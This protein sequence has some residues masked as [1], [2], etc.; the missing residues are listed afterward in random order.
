MIERKIAVLG[1]QRGGTQ[2]TA[3]VLRAN[4]LEVKHEDLG[5]DGIVCGAFIWGLKNYRP[6]H[7]GFDRVV[8]LVRDP[9]ECAETMD[10]FVPHAF[11]KDQ[12]CDDRLCVTLRWWV[13]THHEIERIYPEAELHV[14]AH[15]LWRG[16][17]GDMDEQGVRGPVRGALRMNPETGEEYRGDPRPYDKRRAMERW[18]GMDP[19]WA[20]AG[21]V[22]WLEA[23]EGT[24]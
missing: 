9:I 2:Y 5:P 12:D 15:G 21:R 18:K 17:L 16:A 13:A 24:K 23:L 22:I 7:V 3:R 6:S 1:T 8:H 4:G 20:E 10:R 11:R 19:L 14:L